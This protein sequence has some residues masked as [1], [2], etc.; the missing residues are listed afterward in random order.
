MTQ[1]IIFL[2]IL[3]FK[4]LDTI[5]SRNI[6]AKKVTMKQASILTISIL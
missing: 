1:I 4:H 5:Y 3:N 6:P 2:Y